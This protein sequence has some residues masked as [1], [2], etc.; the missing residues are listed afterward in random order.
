MYETKCLNAN[1]KILWEMW[2]RLLTQVNATGASGT[3]SIQRVEMA[4][5]WKFWFSWK[6]WFRNSHKK[7]KGFDRSGWESLYWNFTEILIFHPVDN[8]LK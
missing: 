3:K 1:K 8:Q 7:K 5:Y 6:S 4:R 2:T